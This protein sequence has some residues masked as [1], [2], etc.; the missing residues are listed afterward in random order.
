VPAYWTFAA[1]SGIAFAITGWLAAPGRGVRRVA[2][3]LTAACV[4]PVLIALQTGQ[5]TALIAAA[6]LLGWW[7]AGR[8]RQISAG[9]VLVVL[10]LKPQVAILVVP[11]MLVAGRRRLFLAWAVAAALLTLASLVSLGAH[12]VGQLRNL[13]MMEE[14]Q[15]ANLAWTLA[16]LVGSGALATGLQLA[17]AGL[18]LLAAWWYRQKSIELVVV[19]G[20][21]GTLLAAP[22]HHPSDFLILAPA[23]WLYLRAS[24]P[25]WQKAWL[26]VG[27]LATYVAARYGPD[28]LL[29]FTLGWLGILGAEALWEANEA[30]RISQASGANAA[31]W[32]TPS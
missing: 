7:L 25:A 32:I 13:L 24:V 21:V 11:A 1:L 16:T 15:S 10:L 29:L 26:V 6:T 2:A 3:F 9:L 31:T 22:Y 18:A 17:C 30:R 23:A 4:Y 14:G 20:I 5:V 27:L 28:L 8:G 12:G 19:A